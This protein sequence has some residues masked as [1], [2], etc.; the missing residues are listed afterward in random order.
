MVPLEWYAEVF[1]A[2]QPDFSEARVTHL[3]EVLKDFSD[4]S[5]TQ[6][7]RCRVRVQSCSRGFLSW[8]ATTI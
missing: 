6:Q 2:D 7:F 4:Q 5:A 3:E 1:V 8:Q